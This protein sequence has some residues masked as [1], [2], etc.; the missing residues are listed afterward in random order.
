M[1]EARSQATIGCRHKVSHGPS[2]RGKL[3]D[4]KELVKVQTFTKA[5]LFFK[6]N[7]GTNTAARST[8]S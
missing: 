3:E 4:E 1:S 8:S 2:L 7:Q 6:S 5:F